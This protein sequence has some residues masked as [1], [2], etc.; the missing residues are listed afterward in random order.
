[1]STKNNSVASK[2]ILE[3]NT[4][5]EAM[6]KESTA[7]LKTLLSDVVK[8]TLRER[9]EKNDDYVIIEGTKAPKDVKEDEVEEP[10]QAEA[11]AEGAEQAPVEGDA[12]AAEAPEDEA[13][14]APVEGTEN[15]VDMAQYQVGDDPNTLDLTGEED[16]NKVIAV[17]KR[18]N[19]DDRVV[20]KKEGSK[21]SLKD[22]DTDAE[23]VIDL[24]GDE[25][26]S[27]EEPA[28]EAEQLAEGL[29]EFEVDFEDEDDLND[30][31][32]EATD[33]KLADAESDR[34]AYEAALND[35][36]GEFPDGIIDMSD[37]APKKQEEPS[38]EDEDEYWE[39]EFA[40]D[41]KL[42]DENKIEN[43][44]KKEKVYEIDLG[45]T[46]DYQKK[47]PIAGLK[48]DGDTDLDA[49]A[50]KDKTAKPW[51]ELE[52]E[53]EPYVNEEDEVAEDETEVVAEEETDE[54]GALVPEEDELDENVTLPKQ[55]KKVKNRKPANKQTPK[56]GHH[57]SK[58]GEYK[59]MDEIVA[60]NNALKE[61]VAGLRAEL[62]EAYV[63]N[64]NL[65][66][67]TKLFLENTTS[68]KEKIDI[69]NRFVN[70][71]K[72]VKQSKALYEAIN[73]ELKKNSASAPVLEQ[74]SM[75]ATAQTLN[76][77][78]IYES[79]DLKEMK[80]FMRRVNNCF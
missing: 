29:D 9:I 8:D 59:A 11:P 78:K 66:K 36:E 1:M 52:P 21:I 44:M 14:E 76:E 45:Y 77:T 65:G 57:N 13:G 74:G 16:P 20:I 35:M 2:A 64:V 32:Y 10:E 17:Y 42:H 63:T 40:E 25:Q 69:V 6:K 67:I 7:T 75:T 3:M 47:D 56:V 38:V 23:Y 26:A 24:Q 27:E 22:N 62:K 68:Q 37:K 5:R 73:K 46:D 34:D 53:Q 15:D 28:A 79:K 61:A 50:P 72:T 12:A 4:I 80:D 39:N 55:R 41:E 31:G 70:E 19:N 58:G 54:C 71:A 60:E 43:S 48:M 49:G 30:Y 18:L 33:D 51:S